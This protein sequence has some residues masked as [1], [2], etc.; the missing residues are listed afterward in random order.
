[1]L[2]NVK[3]PTIVGILTFFSVINTVSESLK[4]KGVFI[5]HYLSFYE[6][7]KL[8]A[9]LNSFITLGPGVILLT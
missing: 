9:Q 4:A 7:L 3:M 6:Q 2:V 8:D 5:F 1:M